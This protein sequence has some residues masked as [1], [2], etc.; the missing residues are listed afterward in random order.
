MHIYSANEASSLSEVVANHFANIQQ[1]S[2]EAHCDV[3]EGLV[4]CKVS[5]FVRTI[6]TVL[7]IDINSNIV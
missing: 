1:E 7:N 3:K 4:L 2:T 6:R 5:S